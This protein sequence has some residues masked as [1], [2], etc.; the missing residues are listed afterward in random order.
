MAVYEVAEP[1]KPQPIGTTWIERGYP[2]TPIVDFDPEPCIVCG[3]PK[4]SCTGE[5]HQAMSKTQIRKR[6]TITRHTLTE[7]TEPEEVEVTEEGTDE[8]PDTSPADPD[9]PGGDQDTND[10]PDDAQNATQGRPPG[11]PRDG[12][13]LFPG[14]PVSFDGEDRGSYMV[15]TEPVYRQVY[16]ENTVSPT[17]V[18]VFPRG[19]RIPKS[20]LQ[21]KSKPKAKAKAVETVEVK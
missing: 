12:R 15:V 6:A 20:M 3:V 17:Y 1:R 2:A 4:N 7:N 19:H 16:R 14:D 21:G 18:L 9:N 13:I 5:T 8:A 11:A 10:T